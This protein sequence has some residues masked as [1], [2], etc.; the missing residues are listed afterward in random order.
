MLERARAAEDGGM[1]AV[2][3][4]TLGRWFSQFA[5]A[6]PNHAGVAYA[7]RCLLADDPRVFAAYWRAMAVHDVKDRLAGIRMPVTVI[8]GS[9]DVAAPA[10]SLQAMADR[11]P[12]SRF[13]IVSGPHILPLEEPERFAAAIHRHRRWVAGLPQV[14]KDA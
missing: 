12:V 13:E 10:A 4:S 14:Q 6:D 11:L 2:V 9:I 8:T 7:R 5:L 3:A 1:E